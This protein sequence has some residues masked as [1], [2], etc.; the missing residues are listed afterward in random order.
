MI[1]WSPDTV[2]RLQLWDIAGQE[3]FGNMTRVY[4]KEAVGALVVF[5]VTRIS[6]FDGVTKWKA[7]IDEKIRLPD[8]SKIP[9]VLLA[10][11]A[12]LAKDAMI[13]NTYG[14]MEKFCQEKEFSGWFETSAK[15]NLNIDDACRF[16]VGK[17]LENDLAM[18][19]KQAASSSTN[20]SARQGLVRPG[21]DDRPSGGAANGGG[22]CCA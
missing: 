19:Q 1:Q 7:D 12:D 13:R 20:R 6:T 3:R 4:Y 18:M 16:L 17:V 15:D 10:N 11:K 8:G 2:I 14:Q 21:V 9:V 22:S 5:D